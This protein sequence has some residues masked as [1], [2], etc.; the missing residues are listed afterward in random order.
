[1]LRAMA[2]RMLRAVLLAAISAWAVGAQA[3]VSQL[4]G[5]ALPTPTGTS[6]TGV[7]TS[8]GFP[9]S[10]VT[11]DGLFKARGETLDPIM[12]A[13]TAPGLFSPNCGFSGELLLRGGSCKVAFGWYNADDPAHIFELVPADT[14]SAFMCTDNDFCPLATMDTTQVGQH[15]W[16]PKAFYADDIKA[17]PKYTGGQIGFA[18][19]GDEATQ[20]KQTKYSDLARNTVSTMYGKPW[21]TTLV[22]Q[23][24]AN[25]EG[26][27]LAFEDL[28]MSPE[29]WTNAGP[30]SPS[31]DGDFNDFVYFIN[32]LSCT[33]GG[34][35]CEVAGAF[36]ACSV[37]RTDC[38]TEGTTGMCRPI[39]TAGAELCDNVDNDCNGMVDDGDGLCPESQVCDK[40]SCV[41]ACGTGE[42]RCG[43]GLTCKGGHCIEDACADKV[44]EAGQA[45]RGGTCMNACDNVV[46]PAG[47]E[48]QLGRCVDPCKAITC[49][50]GKVCERGLC[51]SDCNCRG[52][53]NGLQCGAD[54][55]CTDPRCA[56]VQCMAGEKCVEGACINSCMGVVCP[57]GGNCVNGA[58]QMGTG[59]AMSGGGT[60]G[61]IL[62]G[63][64][65]FG[66]NTGS[67]SNNAD[68]SS[69]RITKDPGC[70]C[71]LVGSS[72][73]GEAALLLAG[74]GACVAFARR[75]QKRA[76]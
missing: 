49:A 19:I 55:R 39:I 64:L 51:V 41:G 65:N 32:G 42:F 43:S 12:S 15:T 23:S 50:A 14:S 72:P 57:G 30:G 6:E 45:C 40:G 21:I 24:T 69:G 70:A 31:N 75:R 54:G 5:T 7:V 56:D 35:P 25:P 73:A 8:R 58:C 29:S 37:G 71:T 26:F 3:Q 33:G 34:L 47:E 10:A 20:C 22:Y 44:C 18:M 4:D 11:L 60:D 9:A 53:Q 48:C 38:A 74:L 28:A 66:G 17:N 63:S 68:G 46:C 59:G 36:G 61:I 27:Y 2:P 13:R 62:G 76:A 52:C 16:T 67:G 1:M